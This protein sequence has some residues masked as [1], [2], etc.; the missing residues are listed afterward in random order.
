[1]RRIPQNAN[2]VPPSAPPGGA[3]PQCLLDIAGD[4]GALMHGWLL[5]ELET[6]LTAIVRELERLAA[7]AAIEH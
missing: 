5:P 6:D 1:M 3:L 4:L 7:R 2:S